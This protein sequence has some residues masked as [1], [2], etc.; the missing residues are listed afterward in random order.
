MCDGTAVAGVNGWIFLRNSKGRVV[1]I[2]LNN[3][4]K[5]GNLEGSKLK[6]NISS[7]FG[8]L[9]ELIYLRIACN[10]SVSGPIPESLGDLVKLK[11]LYLNGNSLGGAI[12]NPNIW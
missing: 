9:E 7:L 10:V 1:R 12:P 2:N 4:E 8:Q 5:K 6:G 3:D 11:R